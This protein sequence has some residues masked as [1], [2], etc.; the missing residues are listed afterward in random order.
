MSQSRFVT[1]AN[2]TSVS[3][4]ETVPTTR[5]I[6]PSA[7]LP[8]RVWPRAIS[9]YGSARWGE[10]KANPRPHPLDIMDSLVFASGREKSY[11]PF[12]SSNQLEF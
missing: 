12:V 3:A 8:N 5:G 6:L 1:A 2:C 10:G 11:N 7:N 9:H 4:W